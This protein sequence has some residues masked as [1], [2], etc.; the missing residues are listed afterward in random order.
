MKAFPKQVAGYVKRGAHLYY[1][2]LT[3]VYVES[4]TGRALLNIL[5]VAVD[6]DTNLAHTLKTSTHGS[7][8][9]FTAD[10]KIVATTLPLVT[11]AELGS[12]SAATGWC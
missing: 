11:A 10:R 4:S 5:L 8:F 2:V 3:P 1:V 9:V 7:D 12:G 6:I